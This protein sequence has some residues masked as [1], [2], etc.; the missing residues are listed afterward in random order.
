MCL[1]FCD[2]DENGKITESI[3][4][5]RVIPMKQ[6]QYF[7]FLMEDVETISQNIPNYKVI[8]GQLKFEG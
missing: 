2:V 5:E 3:L 1:L 7:F 4:G 8:D 6:Y